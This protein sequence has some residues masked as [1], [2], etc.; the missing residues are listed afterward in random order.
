M[1]LMLRDLQDEGMIERRRK[2]PVGSGALPHVTVLDIFGRDSD[3]GLLARPAEWSGEPGEE[4]PTVELRIGQT[5]RAGFRRSANGPWR[6]PFQTMRPAV[7]LI[8][9]AS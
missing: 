3:G 4:A 1:K 7:H 9:P 2:R 6:E 5:T 8:L